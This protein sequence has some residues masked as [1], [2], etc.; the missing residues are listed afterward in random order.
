LFNVGFKFA[1]IADVFIS[2]HHNAF[3][4]DAQG[5]ECL[6]S[7]RDWASAGDK[8]LANI[9]AAHCALKLGIRDR[10][11]R[12]KA[13]GLSILSGATRARFEGKDLKG[14]EAA[15]LAEGYFMDDKKVTDHNTW[16][17]KYGVA[18]AQGVDEFLSEGT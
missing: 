11:F 13:R 1:Q 8:K 3:N 9:I 15:V 14:L 2:I 12:D 17:T 10:N 16:S 5:A 18:L 4:N 7:A 6:W